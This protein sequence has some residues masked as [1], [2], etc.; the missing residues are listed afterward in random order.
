MIAELSVSQLAIIEQTTLRLERGFTVLTGETGAGKSLLIDAI[1]LALG[2]RADSDLVRDQ[3]KSANVSVAFDLS[4]QP[5]LAQLCLDLSVP[6]EDAVLYVT[7]ELFAE[8]RSQCRLGGRLM[9]ASVLRQL[10][11]SLVDLHG[12]HDHQ[13]LL[14][15]DRH[16][17]YLDL[18]IGQ[19][20]KTLRKETQ[21]AFQSFSEAKRKLES[22]RADIQHR[23]RKLDLLRFQ[24]EEIEAVAPA[25]GEYADLQTTLSRLQN[26]ERLMTATETAKQ[27]LSESDGSALELA[28]QALK[29]LEE[30][31]RHDPALVAMA[32]QLRDAIF[33][34]EDLTSSLAKF[35]DGLEASPDA[36]EQTS[37]RLEALRKLRRKYG[38]DETAILQLLADAKAQLGTLEDGEVNEK[39]LEAKVNETEQKLL[40]ETKK[41][42][43]LRRARSRHFSEEI[44]AEFKDLALQ[45]ARFGVGIKPSE[46]S[47]TGAD[48]VEFVFSANPGEP[49]RPLQRVASGGEVSRLMLAMKTVLAGKAGVPTLIFDEI[50][51]GMGGRVGAIVGRKLADLAAIYQVLVISHLPQVAALASHH[52]RIEKTETEG[53]TATRVRRLNSEE[54][55]HEIARMLAGEQVSETALAHAK[56]LLGGR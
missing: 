50:D 29:A 26:L 21:E 32:S 1:Q 11:D 45:N 38:D 44:E 49:L 47:A 28:G 35:A 20:A 46:P 51:S 5:E 13:S 27:S 9:P 52:F 22:V 33:Q 2:E 19:D 4:G 16:L 43:D 12:Q 8:G 42:S 14:H 36:L 25:V 18:W 24:V 31:Q 34:M 48:E 56:E 6:L 55:L 37:N 39:L 17:D 10:G 30:A 3:A 23:E 40:A 54:R 53:R 41:L 7:R 15:Q